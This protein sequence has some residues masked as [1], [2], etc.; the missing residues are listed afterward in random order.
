M[1]VVSQAVESIVRTS[2]EFKT[3]KATC[4]SL[5][6]QVAKMR[7]QLDTMGGALQHLGL[8]PAS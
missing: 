6:D 4:T 3:L 8:K 7:S 1:G 2:T 5:G